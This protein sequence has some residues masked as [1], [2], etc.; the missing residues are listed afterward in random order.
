MIIRFR[1]GLIAGCG[2]SW[3]GC[4]VMGW[5]GTLAIMSMDATAQPPAIGT[6]LLESPASAESTFPVIWEG[7]DHQ[8]TREPS[9]LISP[10][11]FA[12]PPTRQ[13]L[14]NEIELPIERFRRGFFQGAEISGG[15]LSDGSDSPVGPGRS[16]GL[17]ETFWEARAGFGVPLGS[18]KNILAVQPFF[19]ADH[20]EGPVG[21]DAPNTLYSTGVTLFQRKQWNERI[22][23]VVI[24]TPSVRSDFSTSKNAFRLFGLG[25]VNWQC[26]ENLSVGLGA[27]FLDRA[28][29]G[30][31][32]AIGLTWTPTPQWRFDLVMPRPQ[33][34]YRVWK[35]GAQAEGW[36]FAGASLG[37]NTWAVTR[38]GGALDGQDDE[39]TVSG[40]RLFTGYETNRAGNRGWRVEGGLVFNRSIEY[41]QSDIDF[42]L[43]DAL[44]IQSTWRF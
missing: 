20:L 29:L 21:I 5:V 25:L 39:L 34:N 22:S 4:A 27:V 32:P 24:V 37:G 38:D 8:S 40:I 23:T 30:V 36:A 44:F 43:D 35:D 31:L 16:G 13:V 14:A 26:R 1:Y 18:L 7:E 41:E 33:V 2:R 3:I 28:D 42:D 11:S 12:N 9:A 10:A 15:Y 19:R 6:G 17:G